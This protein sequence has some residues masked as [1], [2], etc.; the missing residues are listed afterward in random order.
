MLGEL[1]A[2]HRP[3]LVA[4]MGRLDMVGT[5]LMARSGRRQARLRLV[6]EE[7]L[8][9]CAELLSAA[10]AEARKAGDEARA[11]IAAAKA[12]DLLGR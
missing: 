9:R 6:A 4:L 7:D 3:A 8:E 5:S 1:P 11:R 12:E 10:S 2:E